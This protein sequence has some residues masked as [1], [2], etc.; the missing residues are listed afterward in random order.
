VFQRGEAHGDVVLDF[1]G[2]G[3]AAGDSFLFLGFGTSAGGASLVQIDATR[4]Q[5]NSAD[6]LAQEVITL[7]NAANVHASDYLFA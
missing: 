5:I 7:A 4:W 6:G 3:A 1:A 2:N